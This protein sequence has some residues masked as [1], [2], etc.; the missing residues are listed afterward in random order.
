MAHINSG[1]GKCPLGILRCGTPGSVSSSLAHLSNP[2]SIT[3]GM[4]TPLQVQRV[5]ENASRYGSQVHLTVRQEV[6]IMGVPEEHLDKALAELGD[7]GLRPGSAG[8]V[9]RNVVSCLGATYCFKAAV[10]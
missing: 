2:I 1:M 4:L 3:G 8:M 9:F 6:S 10:Q 7:A 5:G